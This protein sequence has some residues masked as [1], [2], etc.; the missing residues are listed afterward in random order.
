V[1]RLVRINIHNITVSPAYKN[2]LN[3]VFVIQCPKFF[4]V[5]LRIIAA[6]VQLILNTVSIEFLFSIFCLVFSIRNSFY[7]RC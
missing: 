7:L 3:Y 5:L 2:D 1:K 6:A 4:N